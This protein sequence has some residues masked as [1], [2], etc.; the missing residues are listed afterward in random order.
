MSLEL[1][2]SFSSVV[3]SWG[4]GGGQVV[5]VRHTAREGW[6]NHC[7]SCSMLDNIR[8]GGGGG[9]HGGERAEEGRRREN[10]EREGGG[11]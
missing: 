3:V 9:V 8:A 11:M 2:Q 1:E 7:P 4:R 5:V 6:L 10:G